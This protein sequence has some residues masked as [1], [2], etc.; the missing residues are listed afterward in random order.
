MIY[1]NCIGRCFR[2]VLLS[3]C[4]LLPTVTPLDTGAIIVKVNSAICARETIN[5]YIQS[6]LTE[7]LGSIQLIGGCTIIPVR[8][9]LTQNRLVVDRVLATTNGGSWALNF[10]TRFF[11]ATY[12]AHIGRG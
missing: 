10:A 8:A 11:S 2:N 1:N 6:D 5:V 9:A 4:L 3:S 7:V 12:G